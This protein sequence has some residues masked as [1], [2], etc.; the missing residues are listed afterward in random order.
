[1]KVLGTPSSQELHA[2]NPNYPQNYN[3]NPPLTKLPWM[4]VLKNLAKEDACDLVDQL[5]RYDP[6]KRLPPM[7]CMAHRFF[8][9]LREKEST[10]V[11]APLFDFLEDELLF[12]T[13]ADQGLLVPAW[14]AAKAKK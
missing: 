14:Y 4:E 10:V 1:M 13:A 11:T 9:S 8:D 3:F 2:M 12:A 6:G 5:V 7:H